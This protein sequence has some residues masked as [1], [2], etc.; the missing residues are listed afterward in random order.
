[1]APPAWL[2]GSACPQR[3]SQAPM[4][5]SEPGG[6]AGQGQGVQKA[7]AGIL[8]DADAHGSPFREQGSSRRR[9][10]PGGQK[11]AR[12]ESRHVLSKDSRVAGAEVLRSPGVGLA[13]AE[14]LRSPGH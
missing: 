8:K 4:V 13:G 2:C 14:V 7:D 6:G 10:L 12:A 5:V 3:A 9:R 11:M 1:M